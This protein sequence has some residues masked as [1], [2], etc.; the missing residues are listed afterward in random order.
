[1][2][3]RSALNG[4]ARWAVVTR[5]GRV[6][7]SPRRA[8]GRAGVWWFPSKRPTAGSRLAT[9]AL[10]P[11]LPRR[12]Q[13]VRPGGGR[14]FPQRR[15]GRRRWVRSTR[16]CVAG[17]SFPLTG[18]YAPGFQRDTLGGRGPPSTTNIAANRTRANPLYKRLVSAF[19]NAA[20]GFHS[21]PPFLD[22]HQSSYRDPAGAE[23]GGS[24]Y[25]A[26][27][28]KQV[29]NVTRPPPLRILAARPCRLRTSGQPGRTAHCLSSDSSLGPPGARRAVDLSV[30]LT[31]VH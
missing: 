30:V 9:P 4:P 18:V 2:G 1:L 19:S 29:L 12:A 5:P 7:D 27:R 16:A 25:V 10:H 13:K 21:G 11:R 31:A 3:G 8:V 23:N 6:V 14:L 28:D 22:R 15:S 17:H 24:T 26:G 20:F